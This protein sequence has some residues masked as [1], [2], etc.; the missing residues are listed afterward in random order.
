MSFPLIIPQGAYPT[1]V[2]IFRP[3]AGITVFRTL[4]A[5]WSSARG[6]TGFRPLAGI[7][8]F[9][10]ECGSVISGTAG[11]GFRPL[12]GITVFRTNPSR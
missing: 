7:T 10:T 9:R 11:L 1:Y 12:A 8:V 3:L 5:A 6:Y 2:S 4:S